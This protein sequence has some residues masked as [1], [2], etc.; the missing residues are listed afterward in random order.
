[1]AVAFEVLCAELRKRS[2]PIVFGLIA[3]LDSV[4]SIEFEADED[5]DGSPSDS[6]KAFVESVSALQPSYVVL[7]RYELCDK[8]ISDAMA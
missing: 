8:D 6:C 4:L 7:R 1:M 3:T 5:D 2:I